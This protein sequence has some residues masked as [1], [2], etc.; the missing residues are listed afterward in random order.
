M[1]T[2]K[3]IAVAGESAACLY[4][5]NQG[6]TIDHRNFRIGH[7]ETDIICENDEYILFV[8]VKTRSGTVLRSKY[9]SA[10]DA[11]DAKKL[12]RIT[13]CAKEY[14]RLNKPKKKPR[15]DVIEVYFYGDDKPKINHIKNILK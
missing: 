9:G 8:E 10:K 2:R 1:K 4:L 12:A 11:V 14:L 13:N 5:E 3:E 15:I 7:L 6:F